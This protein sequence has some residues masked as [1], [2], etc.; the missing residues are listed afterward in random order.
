V[1]KIDVID[2]FG[3]VGAVA[4]A[5]KINGSAV[6]QWGEE[7][8]IRRAYELERITKG[9]LKVSEMDGEEKAA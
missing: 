3:S 4:D 7:I 6:S 9:A 2:H 5:L 8:P 1:K